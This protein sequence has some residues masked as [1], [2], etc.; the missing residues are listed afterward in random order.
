MSNVSLKKIA[1]YF[2]PQFSTA[3]VATTSILPS[4]QV[5]FPLQFILS[6]IAIQIKSL[7]LFACTD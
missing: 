6:A 5:Q 7:M 3:S 2:L 4:V 1:F